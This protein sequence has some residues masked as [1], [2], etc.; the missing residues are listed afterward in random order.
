MAVRVKIKRD[1]AASWTVGNPVLGMG[2]F[3]YE[4]DTSRIKVG[5]AGTPWAGLSY[6]GQTS[7][8]FSPGYTFAALPSA[9]LNTRS[10]VFVTDQAGVPAYSD[11]TD[12]RYYSSNLVVT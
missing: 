4:T 7:P 5:D 1:I 2:E 11:G 3:G 9:S 10:T 8:T 12:W 6:L